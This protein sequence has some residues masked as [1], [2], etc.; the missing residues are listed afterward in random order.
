MM[1]SVVVKMYRR[2]GPG[3]K[4]LEMSTVSEIGQSVEHLM[5]MMMIYQATR[6]NSRVLYAK[7]LPVYC[8]FF[9]NCV[10]YH[11]VNKILLRLLQ[12]LN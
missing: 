10:I 2:A 6:P 9:L 1:S 8:I 11:Y 7:F 4:E 3:Q 5:M 12:F